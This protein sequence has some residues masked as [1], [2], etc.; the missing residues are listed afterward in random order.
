MKRIQKLDATLIAQIAAGEVIESPAAI[1]KEL[2]EN[3]LDAGATEI[4]IRIQGDGFDEIQVRDNGGGIH[5]AD[6]ELAVTIFATS[7][8][9]SLEDLISARTQGLRSESLGP[10]ASVMRL[11]SELRA[12]G[13]DLSFTP[14]LD[15]DYGSSGVIGDRAFHR[16]PHG[17]AELGG[18]L[19]GGLHRAGMAACG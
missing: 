16:D 7:K 8:I 15:L 9:A 11:T 5:A 10:L 18:A 1:V 4:D 13:V 14:V 6:L 2:V 19:I 3:S 17:V 12:R